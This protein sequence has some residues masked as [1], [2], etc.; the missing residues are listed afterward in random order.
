MTNIWSFLLQTLMASVVAVIL[1]AVKSFWRINCP[2][3]G[4]MGCGVS[5]YC[6]FWYL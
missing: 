1:L 5:W 3:G 4:S 2:Q 6:G